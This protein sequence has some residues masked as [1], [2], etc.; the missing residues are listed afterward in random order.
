MISTPDVPNVTF[1]SVR[2]GLMAQLQLLVQVSPM[3][4]KFAQRVEWALTSEFPFEIV[5]KK[6]Y[7]QEYLRCFRDGAYIPQELPP[8]KPYTF[9]ND[10]ERKA[11][12]SSENA[13]TWPVWIEIPALEL[14]FRRIDFLNGDYL[15]ARFGNEYGYD[16][17]TGKSDRLYRICKFFLCTKDRPAFDVR[18]IAPTYVIEY[19]KEHKA[20]IAGTDLSMK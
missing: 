20:E 3:W 19:L 6:D 13:A 10:A 11:F 15:V 9:K 1:D 5:L 7:R 4:T 17:T 16:S 2:S 18:G 8:A 12:A 14:T